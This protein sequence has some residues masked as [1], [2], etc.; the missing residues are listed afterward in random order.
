[1]SY[2]D[3]G[4]FLKNKRTL[5]TG[6]TGFIGSC[7]TR[8][9]VA[10]GF[11]EINV[12][13]RG[14]SD[15]WR[16]KDIEKS[17]HIS[18]VDLRDYAG[19]R[20]IILKIRPDFIFHCASYGGFSNQKKEEEILATN[21]NGTINLINSLSDVDYRHFIN[22]GSSSEYGL[23]GKKMSEKDD[24]KPVTMYG[25]SKAFSAIYA[26]RTAE[27]QKKPITTIRPFSVYGPYDSRERLIISFILAIL[28]GKKKYRIN[29]PTAV[30]DFVYIDDV[31]DFFLKVASRKTSLGILNIGSG[32]QRTV[33]KAVTEIK[34]IAES[35]I[36]VKSNDDRKKRL[37]PEVWEADMSKAK[38]TLGWKARTDFR[39][40]VKKT[41]DWVRENRRIYEK[42][43]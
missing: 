37:K 22:V 21:I 25:I 11:G 43:N 39:K 6:A 28:K 5:V 8:R 14:E 36:E 9:L 24:L 7:L 29:S 2:Q 4:R 1:M 20:K 33:R 26:G 41:I 17:I 15:K 34:N 32:E 16:I 3:S 27:K 12:L 42:K 35:D 18:R 13:I 40:G 23:K 30:R 10:R 31:T 38:K 19:L